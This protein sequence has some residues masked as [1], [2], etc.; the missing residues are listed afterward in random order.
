MECSSSHNESGDDESPLRV[1][2]VMSLVTGIVRMT[3]KTVFVVKD[4]RL[5]FDCEVILHKISDGMPGPFTQ[6]VGMA[7]VVEVGVIRV[8]GNF[9]A[10]RKMLPL[11][12]SMINSGEFLIIDVIVSFGFRERL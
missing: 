12:K 8:S 6:F 2:C 7:V 4:A 5:V 1:T 3:G 9:V 11:L 10:K